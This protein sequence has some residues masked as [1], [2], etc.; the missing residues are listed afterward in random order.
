MGLSMYQSNAQLN[1]STN[2][3]KTIMIDGRNLDLERG[4]GVATYARNLSYCIRDL[5][6]KVEVLYGNRPS[7]KMP[8]LMKEIAFFDGHQPEVS[9]LVRA[10]RD[11][12]DMIGVRFG[13]SATRVPMSGTVISDAFSSRL[14]YFDGIQNSPNMFRIAHA[15]FSRSR[16]LHPVRLEVQPDLMHWTYPL[17]LGVRGVPNVYTLHDL[18]PL[19][20]PHT[21]LD[22]KKRYFRLVSAIC[23]RA[24]HIITVSESSKADIVSIF[25]VD[26]SRVSNTYQS[27]FIPNKYI[28]R[29]EDNLARELDA[30][31]G[32]TYKN[33]YVYWG[34]IEPKKNIGRLI[35][36]YLSSGVSAPLVIVGA[37]AWKSENELKLINDLRTGSRAKKVR[38]NI[39]QLN[40]VPFALL[41]TLIK[42]ARGAVFPS[43]YE[44]FG[45][46]V[47]EAMVLGTPVITSN[48][49][50]IPEVAGAACI[51][52]NPYETSDI[53]RALAKLDADADLQAELSQRGLRQAMLFS[54][55][56]HT[57]RLRQIY[58]KLL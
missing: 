16:P 9:P 22:N 50:S 31:F 43:L 28:N 1:A 48:T 25:G 18:V 26:P 49:A 10:W 32:L 4:T 33:Y 42:G 34:G 47:L 51:M 37:Q 27:V 3:R 6:H 29:D 12:R 24:D 21:T 38:K 55:A 15:N 44:G 7:H 46:P 52:V 5:G 30:I 58:D 45:L 57:M 41:M 20:L 35:E 8:S 54:Q 53:A 11:V 13:F 36:G 39:I 2:D 56:A 17:P 23:A 19:R 40:Y 14:P